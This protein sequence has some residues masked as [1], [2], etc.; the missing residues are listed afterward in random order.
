M[1]IPKDQAEAR[2]F[3]ILICTRKFCL[4]R[5]EMEDGVAKKVLGTQK[6]SW[7]CH[8]ITCGNPRF[9]AR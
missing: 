3:G 7:T 2:R 6:V 8:I 4:G 9:P 5:E 1:H